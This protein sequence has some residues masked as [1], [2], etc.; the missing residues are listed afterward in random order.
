VEQPVTRCIVITG[1]GSGLGRALAQR[2]AADGDTIILLGRTRSKL[3]AVA[4]ALGP[5]SH[6]VACDVGSVDSVRTAF[7][8]IAERHAKVDVLINNAAIYQ[9][10][11]VQDAT[12]E[13]ISA[14]VMTNF[15]GP[16]YCSRAIIPLMQKGSH[17]INISSETV[18]LPHAMFSLYQSTKA[19]LE[20]FTEALHAELEPRGIRVTLARAGQMMDA[21]SRSPTADP[22]IARRFAEENLKRGLDFRTRP[23]SSFSSVAEVLRMLVRLPE[24]VNVPRI[25][26][27][28]R[29]P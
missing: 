6:A 19:G 4:A 21:D 1:A 12:D 26:L 15:A 9:P 29:R 24:D 23:I 13:Q 22:T 10:F 18:G 14:A 25:L 3:D 5:A 27:E 7:A 28:A 2:L 20:R 17:I 11:F 8:A 16:I